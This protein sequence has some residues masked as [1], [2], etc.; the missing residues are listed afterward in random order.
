MDTNLTVSGA[1]PRGWIA[2]LMRSLSAIVGGYALANGGAIVIA[3]CLPLAPAEA[4]LVALMLSFA[5]FA[6]A[7]LWVFAA[8]SAVR[9][10]LQVWAAALLLASAAYL[11]PPVT[12]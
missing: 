10:C 3:H 4:V 8:P 12:P 7:V 11:L 9:G 1:G 6:A 2:V 5:L